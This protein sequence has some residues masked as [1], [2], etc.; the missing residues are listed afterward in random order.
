MVWI[1]FLCL[2]GTAFSQLVIETPPLVQ[3]II[4]DGD[5]VH[6]FVGQVDVNFNGTQ[7]DGDRP[8]SW[9]IVDIGSLTTTASLEFPWAVVTTSRPAFDNGRKLVYIGIGDSVWAYTARTQVRSSEPI[10][11]G[12]NTALGYNERTSDLLI[13]QRPS[14]TDPGFLVRINLVDQQRSTATVGV[15]PQQ[16][17]TTR[18]LNTNDVSVTICEGVFGQSN[19]SLA[20]VKNDVVT[21]NIVIGDTPNHMAIDDDRGL[22]YV[23]VNGSH[24]LKI[25]DLVEARVRDSVDLGTAGFDGPREV[26]LGGAYAF[27]SSYSSNMHVVDL[28][29]NRL[30]GTIGIPAKADPVAVIGS[31][32]WIG[33][34]FEKGSFTAT[35]NVLVYPINV[36]SVA[37]E[38]GRRSAR[39]AVVVTTPQVSLSELA[40]GDMIS[41]INLSGVRQN[42]SIVDATTGTIDVS[43]LPSGTYIAHN[44]AKNVVLAIVR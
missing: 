34:S 10:F 30:V 4:P 13:S 5:V 8:A 26:A 17:L 18:L 36:V 7:D 9:H 37:E 38:M 43:G 25:V 15:S 31:S 44:G 3:S 42:V 20:I 11:E 2:T 14:F 22:A 21:E 33:L 39:R 27:V 29:T 16:T 41:V 40:S 32:I 28:N 23:A 19:G 1:S 35:G 12:I 6:V 24:Q